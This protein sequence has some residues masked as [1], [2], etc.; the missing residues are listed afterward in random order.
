MWGV[1][2]LGTCW[3][4]RYYDPWGYDSRRGNQS[5]VGSVGGTWILCVCLSYM[6]Y[7]DVLQC[8]LCIR[9]CM[10]IYIYTHTYG[11]VMSL[12]N[13]F[14]VSQKSWLSDSLSVS[15]PRYSTR[16][17]CPSPVWIRL[18]MMRSDC[19]KWVVRGVA[20]MLQKVGEETMTSQH[21]SDNLS[22]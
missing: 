19:R 22:G 11:N 8:V 1:V 21:H 10:Y 2:M 17:W 15:N 9:M 6:R 5:L 3:N 20:K 4:W 16:S 18:R 12:Q 13:W 14:G 7:Y